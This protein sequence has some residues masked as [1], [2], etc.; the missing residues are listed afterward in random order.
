MLEFVLLM[1][2]LGAWG[3]WKCGLGLLGGATG[4]DTEDLNAADFLTAGTLRHCFFAGVAF[5]KAQLPS[6]L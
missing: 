6:I 2:Q 3:T 5:S 1:Q 4:A